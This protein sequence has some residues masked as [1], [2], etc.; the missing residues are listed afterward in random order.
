[1]YVIMAFAWFRSQQYAIYISVTIYVYIYTY[2]YIYLYFHDGDQSAKK[3]KYI[4][5]DSIQVNIP[6]Y[7]QLTM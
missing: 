5:K 7:G 3:Y 2:I 4:R 6:V 1:M